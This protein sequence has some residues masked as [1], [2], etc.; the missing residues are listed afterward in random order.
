MDRMLSSILKSLIRLVNLLVQDVRGVVIY[1]SVPLASP[2]DH[3]PSKIN[4]PG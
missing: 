3:R 2:L 1:G 4:S